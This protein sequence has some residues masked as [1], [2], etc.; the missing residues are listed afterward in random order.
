M[1]PALL[2]LL[3]LRARGLPR[4]L[5]RSLRKPARAILSVLGLGV[6]VLWAGMVWLDPGRAGDRL[7]VETAR[8]AAP[9]LMLMMCLSSLLFSQSRSVQFSPAEVDFLF[10]GPFTRRQLLVYKLLNGLGGSLIVATLLSVPFAR[11]VPSWSAAFLGWLLA[12]FF[13][14][15]LVMALALLSQAVA[16]RVDSLARRA[17]VV[18]LGIAAVVTVWQLFGRN[19]AD[20]LG[21]LRAL[22]ETSVVGVASAPF[23]LFALTMTAGSWSELLRFGLAA[24]GVDAG[25]LVLVLWLDTDF[26]QRSVALRQRLYE[27]SRR[28]AAGAVP[29]RAHG[30]RLRLPQPPRWGGAGGLAW[31]QSTSLLRRAGWRLLVVLVVLMCFTRLLPA[32]ESGDLGADIL[33]CLLV[34]IVATM[35]LDQLVQ[36]DFR[37]EVDHMDCLKSLPVGDL[38]TAA[39]ELFTPVAA[40]TAMHGL[41]LAFL[42]VTMP[43]ALLFLLAVAPFTPPFNLIYFGVDNLLFLLFPARPVTTPGDFQ[44][45]GR[46]L[47]T[48]SAQLGIVTLAGGVATGVGALAHSLSGGSWLAAG[49]AAWCVLTAWALAS[50][51]LVA[52]AFARFDVSRDVPA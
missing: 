26:L 18:A 16:E 45:F 41:L 33:V 46:A 8:V 35:L 15:L 13:V 44:Q 3:L 17:L 42:A 2:R 34:L 48:L 5:L 10:P 22:R 27:R 30:A 52:W 43:Q 38:P 19:A 11:M 31:R 50:I 39:G 28:V 25:M 49:V 29:F 37:G 20:D 24:A 12:L 51:P 21:G 6:F 47:L 23:D 9:L 7:A 14:Q 40:A 4:R 1:H 36:F 32:R